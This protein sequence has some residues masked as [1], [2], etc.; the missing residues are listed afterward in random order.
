MITHS[1]SS[2]GRPVD[3]FMAFR[4]T[5]IDIITSYC[6]GKS[7]DTLSSQFFQSSLLHAMQSTIPVFWVFKYFPRLQFML[8]LPD[9]LTVLISPNL[10]SFASF[11]RMLINQIE[12]VT[13]DPLA[14]ERADREI[15]YH[16]LLTPNPD[17]GHE[18]PSKKSLVDEANTLV[19]AGS[20]TVGGTCTFGVFH[21]ASDPLVYKTLV[22]ELDEAWPDKESPMGF[23][24]LEKL[25]YLVRFT[26]Q[27]HVHGMDTLDIT[28]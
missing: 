3:L 26:S 27:M 7:A 10:K 17:K 21:V 15:V 24:A 2:K 28:I 23:E 22:K 1:L 16:H 25:P 6:F 13:A 19:F 11:R 8:T 5:T 18:I 9:W 4:C 12:E 20:D 14:L